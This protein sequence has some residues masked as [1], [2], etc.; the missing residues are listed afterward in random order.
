MKQPAVELVIRDGMGV[1]SRAVKRLF[2][3]IFSLIGLVLLSP[4]F[5]AVYIMLKKQGD[6]PVIF[7]QEP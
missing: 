5:L 1:L 2:D 7:R 3:I 4:A 6:G